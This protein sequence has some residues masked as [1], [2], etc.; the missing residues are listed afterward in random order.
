M[1]TAKR[2]DELYRSAGKIHI[3]NHSQIVFMS[4]IHRGDNSVID[5][6]GISGIEN[7]K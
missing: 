6:F 1:F 5:E 2:L 3:D 4:D 7:E